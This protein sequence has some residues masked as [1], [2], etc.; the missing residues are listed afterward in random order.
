M[1]KALRWVIVVLCPSSHP[2]ASQ[3]VLATLREMNG[4]LRWVQQGPP[5]AGGVLVETRD[6]GRR[7]DPVIPHHGG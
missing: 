7:I 5:A 3:D 4:A 2:H 1:R 6:D